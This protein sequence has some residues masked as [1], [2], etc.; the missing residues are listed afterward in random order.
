MF[1]ENIK[2]IHTDI[3]GAVTVKEVGKILN[4]M[5]AMRR[6]KYGCMVD[7]SDLPT[8][9]YGRIQWRN[10]VGKKIVVA[11]EEVYA[12]FTI[13]GISR[14]A[15]CHDA[16]ITMTDGKGT[17]KTVLASTIKDKNLGRLFNRYIKYYYR[18][19]EG[20]VLKTGSI[21]D[22]TTPA[23]KIL[24]KGIKYDKDGIGHKAYA[25]ECTNCG[26]L[27]LTEEY[28]LLHKKS[29]CT[30]HRSGLVIRKAS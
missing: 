25:T 3:T 30:C 27:A 1:N 23:I 6:P 16:Y 26:A 11:Y 9:T 8:D 20:D 13:T 28:D 29:L 7:L 22:T 24:R 14:N 19:N 2:A 4:R 5:M 17:Y 10:S 21:T 15:G 12:T 18:L